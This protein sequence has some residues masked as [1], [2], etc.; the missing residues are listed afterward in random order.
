MFLEE[1]MAIQFGKLI[2]KRF[3]SDNGEFHVYRLRCH[4]GEHCMA[5]YRGESAPPARK[6]VELELSGE[7]V[8][9]P[10]YG[11]QFEFSDWKKSNVRS[12]VEQGHARQLHGAL[13]NVG[14]GDRVVAKVKAAIF[15]HGLTGDEAGR[16]YEALA[17]CA[18]E[19][20]AGHRDYAQL[21]RLLTNFLSEAKGFSKQ[22]AQGGNNES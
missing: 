10:E 5:V 11:R 6:T 18:L 20:L 4:G 13:R 3:T 22:A 19:Q 8:K 9:H 16:F 15:D 14:E 1:S 2:D 7:W 21:D 12:L 17:T